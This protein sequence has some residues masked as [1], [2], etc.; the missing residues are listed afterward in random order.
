MWIRGV[1]LSYYKNALTSTASGIGL[2]VR[3]F[4]MDGPG[5]LDQKMLD[6]SP[7]Y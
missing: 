6:V 4:E 5:C 2:P 1:P 7:S 3:C